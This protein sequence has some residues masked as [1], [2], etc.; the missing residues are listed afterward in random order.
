MVRDSGVKVFINF[1]PMVYIVG[2]PT[3]PKLRA[4]SV[5]M[6][7]IELMWEKTGTTAVV[8]WTLQIKRE[9]EEWRVVEDLMLKS[10]ESR[11]VNELKP[12]TTYWFRAIVQNNEGSSLFSDVVMVTTKPLG[13]CTCYRTISVF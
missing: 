6:E 1:L 5:G 9:M 3:K 8:S 12:N 7:E 4:T 11:V 2:A 13:M 10:R